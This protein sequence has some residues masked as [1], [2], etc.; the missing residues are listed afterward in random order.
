MLRFWESEFKLMTPPKSR[1]KQR[2]GRKQ[3]IETILKI[4]QLLYAE[5]FTIEIQELRAEAQNAWIRLRIART[6]RGACGPGQRIS[7]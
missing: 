4:Y 3:D 6:T 7:A 2:M 5:R 1:S